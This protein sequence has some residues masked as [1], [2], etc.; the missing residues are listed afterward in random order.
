MSNELVE[1]EVK[2]IELIDPDTTKSEQLE[3][4]VEEVK[5]GLQ[6]IAKISEI[7]IK[8]LAQL[9]K[10]SQHPRLYE[11]LANA[12][13]ATNET[14]REL[15]NVLRTKA[16]LLEKGSKGESTIVDNRT[17]NN[18]LYVTSTELLRKLKSEKKNDS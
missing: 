2:T 8:D 16:E 6:S 17:V 13:K 15:T 11:A 9:A 5:A 18:N 10:S 3:L 12:I 1:K 14:H 7:A 4:E